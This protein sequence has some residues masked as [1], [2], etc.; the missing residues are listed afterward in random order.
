MFRAWKAFAAVALLVGCDT[1]G[2]KVESVATGI[3]RPSQVAVYLSVRDGE[4]PLTDLTPASFVVFEDGQRLDAGQVELSL[5]DRDVAAVHHTVLLIDT[6]GL[7]AADAELVTHAVEAF[8]NTVSASQ[9][10]SV[11]SFDGSAT[12]RPLG[13][14]VR[15]SP[16]GETPFATKNASNKTEGKQDSGKPR[17]SQTSSDK[18]E[19]AKREAGKPEK[20][21]PESRKQETA[22]ATKGKTGK[23]EVS[24]ASKPESK[25]APLKLAELV[26]E[27]T[28]PSRDLNGA[29]LRGLQELETA[30][31][32]AD[33]PVRVG[34]LVVFMRGSDLAGR[35]NPAELDAALDNS[36][37]AIVA[38]AVGADQTLRPEHIGRDGVFR[39]PTLEKLDQAFET[40]ADRVLAIEHSHYLVAYCSPARA[41]ERKLRIEVR[42][43]GARG[44]PISGNFET[45]FDA[46][47]FTSGCNAKAPPE[48]VVTL[49]PGR[50]GQIP[51]ALPQGV[52]APP[53]PEQ[54]PNEEAET[55]PKQEPEPKTKQ[56]PEPKTKAP[57]RAPAAKPRPATP[58][59]QA[60]PSDFEP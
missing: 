27:H 34:T 8:V 22:D 4:R 56:E 28:D 37:A 57:K 13:E 31:S 48:F 21:K 17:E 59:P 60:P 1:G 3:Q 12:L 35:V 23:A 18:S 50:R 39:L 5:L 43:V 51:A 44:E 38:I 58:Q 54:K 14:V 9:A 6:S 47:G 52:E 41:G 26:S 32:R 55:K 53:K 19:A 30:L 33:K 20:A 36:H 42:T 10:I 46:R 49:A 25:T 2:L 45:S 7:T 24:E 15:A 40:A 11:Y 16:A 29:V